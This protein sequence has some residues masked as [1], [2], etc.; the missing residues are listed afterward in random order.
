MNTFHPTQ[1][2]RRPE[3]Y[4]LYF[5]TY[6]LFFLTE[7]PK[8]SIYLFQL[9]MTNFTQEELESMS[10]KIKREAGTL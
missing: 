9:A 1:N 5:L 8:I 4:T 7:N 3:F 10:R 6:N 2:P